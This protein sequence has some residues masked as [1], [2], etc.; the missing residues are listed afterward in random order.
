[1][2]LPLVRAQNPADR[3]P[4]V[5]FGVAGAAFAL[6]ATAQL[7]DFWAFDLRFAW[8][9]GNST[10]SAFSWVSAV[11]IF[12]TG[13]AFVGLV[14]RVP[15]HRRITATVAVLFMFLLVDNR[16]HLHERLPHGKVLFLPAL[17]IAFGLLWHFSGLG[18]PRT[19]VL[20]RGGLSFLAASLFI[21]L[22]GPTFL[23]WAGWQ[24]H[25]WQYQVKVA[26]KESTEKAGWILVCF[27][28]LSDL[29]SRHAEQR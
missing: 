7:V 4:L 16:A 8:L 28:A 15:D 11:A 18:S 22:V 13:V 27:G 29:W 17:G 20:V 25:D 23:S 26:L 1:V 2:T 5:A 3:L 10:A 14:V 24:S 9:N 6:Q 12:G 21:H 19:R